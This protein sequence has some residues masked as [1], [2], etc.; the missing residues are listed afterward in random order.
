M[1][2]CAVVLGRESMCHRA[3][4]ESSAIGLWRGGA[5]WRWRVCGIW[6][7]R[8]LMEREGH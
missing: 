2:R 5:S 6:R 4:E 3:R 7:W 1:E 8:A